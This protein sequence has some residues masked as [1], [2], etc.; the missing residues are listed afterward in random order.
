MPMLIQEA[1]N[2]GHIQLEDVTPIPLLETQWLLE[3]IL[4]ENR[5]YLIL[6]A[7]KELC[8]EHEHLLRSAIERRVK[9][10]PLQYII[11]TQEFMGHEFL[12]TPDVLIPRR[13]TECLVELI[14][15]TYDHK[16]E[17]LTISDLGSGSGA[18]GVSIAAGLKQ[19]AVTCVDLSK[20]ALEMTLKN[21][22]RIL[23]GEKRKAFQGVHMDMFEYLDTLTEA[24]QDLIVSNPPY[25]P[26]QDI[27]VLQVE[28]KCHEPRTALDGGKDGLDYYRKLVRMA[29]SKL[30][31]SG[32]MLF[33]VGHDQAEAVAQLFLDDDGYEDIQCYRDLQGVLRIVGAHKK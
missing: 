20:A 32:W 15:D 10:E 6:N 17:P 11:G 8:P 31:H 22:D 16:E 7:G 9:G 1:L 2:F 25:I 3:W 23:Q 18:I 30:K 33:E 29:K 24:S 13:D 28:V 12:V 5:L 4:E 27:E 26:S 19:T 14:L 21:A